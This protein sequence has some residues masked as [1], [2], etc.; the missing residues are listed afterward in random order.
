MWSHSIGDTEK[1]ETGVL[2]AGPEFRMIQREQKGDSGLS[3]P[4]STLRW[5]GLLEPI[6][7]P[8]HFTA[9]GSSTAS[10]GQIITG[11]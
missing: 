6:S 7:H 3:I 10:A 5:K 11:S 8:G 4:L 2:W 9:M 1:I